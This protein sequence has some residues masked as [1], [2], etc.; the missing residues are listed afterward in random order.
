MWQA[1]LLSVVSLFNE[2][3]CTC[4]HRTAKVCTGAIVPKVLILIGLNTD[5]IAIFSRN[6]AITRREMLLPDYYSAQACVLHKPR[7]KELSAPNRFRP[8]AIRTQGM[9]RIF[10]EYRYNLKHLS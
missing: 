3:A 9:Y 7:I 2:E 10:T 4:T 6:P 5:S 1:P 8:R